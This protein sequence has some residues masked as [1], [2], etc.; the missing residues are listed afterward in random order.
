MI[1]HRPACSPWD[2]HLVG[3][4][5]R[6][7]AYYQQIAIPRLQL[8]PPQT[9]NDL[10]N[11]EFKVHLVD[12]IKDFEEGNKNPLELQLVVV[13]YRKLPGQPHPDYQ[14]IE[15]SETDQEDRRF[16]RVEYVLKCNRAQRNIQLIVLKDILKQLAQEQA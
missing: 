3:S 7:T 12:L 2:L 16:D 10:H 15:L 11:L 9:D 14:V 5:K 8:P 1:G 4:C 13:W 6:E